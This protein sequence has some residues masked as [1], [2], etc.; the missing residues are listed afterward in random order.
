MLSQIITNTPIYV[1]AILAFLMYRGI[2]FAVDRELEIRAVVII[3][4]VMLALS[5]QGILSG[6]GTDPLVIV[7]WL[8]A[9]AVG[10]VVSWNGVTEDNVRILKDKKQ[11]FYRGSWAPLI[12][13]MAVFVIK[14]IVNVALHINPGLHTNVQFAVISTALFGMFNGLFLGKMLRVL[15]MYQQETTHAAAVTI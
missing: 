9:M 15:I 4:M 6:F 10:A 8:L 12:M 2:K 7:S 13:M 14:Y 5:A 11:V 1:W 3:P